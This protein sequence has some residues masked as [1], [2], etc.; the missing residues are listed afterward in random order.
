[1]PQKKTITQSGAS[2]SATST[3]LGYTVNRYAT[4]TIS[5]TGAAAAATA[6]VKAR[7]FGHSADVE[8][9]TLSSGDHVSLDIRTGVW[10]RFTI[11]FS[12]AVDTAA[13]HFVAYNSTARAEV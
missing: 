2:M 1:M 3:E 8:V 13:V 5:Y 10:D 9:A 6:T 12:N 7:P 4:H 11:E